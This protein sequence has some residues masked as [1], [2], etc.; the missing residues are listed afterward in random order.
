MLIEF[1]VQNYLS[2]NTPQTLSMLASSSTKENFDE[3]NI[4][5]IN[6]F[7]IDSLL[8]SSAIFGANASGKSNFIK[9]FRAL[10]NIV[11]NSLTTAEAG[12]LDSVLPFLIKD[13]F[14]DIPTEFEVVFLHDGN[15]YRYGIAI[16]DGVI[17]EEWLYWRKT[18]RE[19]MLFH[20]TGQEVQI[21]QRSFSEAKDFVRKEEKKL[22]LE[23]TRENVPFI[24]VLSQFNGEK[25]RR[26]IDWFR[27]LKIVSGIQ[28]AGFKDFTIKLF[29]KSPEF[30][31]WAL[32]ILSSLHIQDIRIVE[33][34]SKIPAPP[35]VV[36]DDDLQVALDKITKFL[37]KNQTKHKTLEIV[38]R[39]EGGT[40]DYSMPLY[41]ESQ[42]TRK[43]IYLLGPIFDVINKGEIL[44]IDEFDNKFHS[45]LSKFIIN[46]YHK[47]NKS[48]SQLIITCHDTNLLT[49]E[50]FRRDQIWFIEKNLNH[51]SELYSL[52]E[53]KEHYTRKDDSYSKDY[54]GGKY[55][56]IPLF[57]TIE[58][59]KMVLDG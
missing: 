18:S 51:E 43:L 10:K 50:L 2:F 27:K 3:E 55:G 33:N 1:K 25:S 36:D 19:T 40:Q 11:L 46:L 8:K 34:D 31:A 45:I 17:S 41:L 53:Y 32:E 35:S 42:G 57:K 7:G 47:K 29:E 56:A 24:S 23:K 49:K 13:D 9:S 38:K 5:P 59:L 26:V 44:L 6:M 54:L 4:F 21:N 20:R 52:L 58:E 16:I 12:N 39:P 37:K 28:E 22:Y 14:F 15:L 30:K 48:N